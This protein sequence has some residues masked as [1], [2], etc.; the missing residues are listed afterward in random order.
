MT[1]RNNPKPG[2]ELLLYQTEDGRT[3]IE[4]RFDNETIWLSQALM[5]DLF[6][7]AVSSVNEHLKGIYAEGELQAGA[8][9]RKFRMVRKEGA[10][11][12]SRDIEHYSLEAILAALPRNQP[13]KR[14][15]LTRRLSSFP[16][17]SPAR[18]P[19]IQKN[20]RS[21]DRYASQPN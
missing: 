15:H 4:C 5:A 12:V 16:P 3:R 21:V 7:V 8:T 9:I 10:R 19:A 20:R 18:N 2:G 1:D 6:Q 14:A 13:K 11:Q 17:S